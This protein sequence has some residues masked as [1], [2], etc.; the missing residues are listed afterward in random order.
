MMICKYCGGKV[1]WQRPILESNSYQN[2]VTAPYL[3]HT[4]CL[5]CGATHSQVLT[6]TSTS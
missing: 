6:E 2:G 1:E 4:K 5:S 3:T